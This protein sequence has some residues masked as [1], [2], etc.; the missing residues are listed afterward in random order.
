MK[1]KILATF[2]AC[3]TIFACGCNSSTEISFGNLWNSGNSASILNSETLR[4]EV[5]YSDSYKE[6]DYNFSK[7]S[8]VTADFEYGTGEYIVNLSV[9]NASKDMPCGESDIIDDL[10]SQND[11]LLF[12]LQTQL[13]IP[14]SYVFNGNTVTATDVVSSDCFFSKSNTSFSP[15]YSKGS[16]LSTF[17]YEN[18][19]SVRMKYD[20]ETLYYKTKYTTSITSYVVNADSSDQEEIE[21]SRNEYSYEFGKTVDNASLLFVLRNAE[22]SESDSVV[23]S[24]V[25]PSYGSAQSVSAKYVSTTATNLSLDYKGSHKSGESSVK[26]LSFGL[27]GG[28]SCSSSYFTGTRQLAYIQTAAD[29]VIPSEKSLVTRYVEP[30][31]TYG[32]YASLGALVYNLKSV[33]FN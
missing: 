19:S 18:T 26:V 9:V 14:V 23:L 24:V 29:S 4:Y 13:T 8:S 17:L 10:L 22:L 2:L 3:A 20:Y 1:K 25:T 28:Q 12:R 5:T 15:V 16:S 33:D 11:Q 7:S 27:Y 21:K 31:T 32:T 6:G 30:L